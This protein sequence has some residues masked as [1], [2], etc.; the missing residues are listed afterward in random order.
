[1]AKK[2]RFSH[3]CIQKFFRKTVGILPHNNYHNTTH[4]INI[5]LIV[6]EH[7][8]RHMY[9]YFNQE[10]EYMREIARSY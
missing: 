5:H 6:E 9:M 2:M 4:H 10:K 3:L 8:E 7:Y 1:M